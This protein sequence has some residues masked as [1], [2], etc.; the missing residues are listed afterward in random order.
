MQPSIVVFGMAHPNITKDEIDSSE[1]YYDDQT[2]LHCNLKLLTGWRKTC[3][4]VLCCIKYC[5]IKVY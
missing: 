4:L 3:G 5:Q 2:S 1:G